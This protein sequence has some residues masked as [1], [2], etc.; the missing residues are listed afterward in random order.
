MRWALRGSATRGGRTRPPLH[1]LALHHF[2]LVFDAEGTEE[3]AG[4]HSG[5]L[6]VHRAVYRTNQRDVTIVD[7]DADR[8]RRIDGILAQRRIAVDGACRTQAQAVVEV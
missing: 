3:L 8:T 2:Q 6:L 5:D 7:D 4:S 1:R